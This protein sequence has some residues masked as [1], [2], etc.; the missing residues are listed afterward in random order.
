MSMDQQLTRTLHDQ[1][2]RVEAPLP[3]L[4]A[5]VAGGRRRQRTT[6]VRR[7]GIA[8][9]AAAAV[10]ATGFAI[11]GLGNHKA[12]TPPVTHD[13][14][15]STVHSLVIGDQPHIPFCA[16]QQQILGADA[17][18]TADCAPLVV[19]G[20][21]TVYASGEG[22]QQLVGGRQ[23]LLDSRLPSVW[24]PAVSIDGS[25]AAW[26]TEKPSAPHHAAMVVYDLSDQHQIAE[27]DWPALDGFAAG[28][29][30]RGRVYFLDNRTSHVWVYD[31]S[32]GRT[33]EVTGLPAFNYPGIRFVTADGLGIDAGTFN[34]LGTPTSRSV[35]GTVT[36]NG[37]FVDQHTVPMGWGDFSPDRGH[38][39]Q[40]TADGLWVTPYDGHTVDLDAHVRLQLP[41][42]GN[43]VSR[44]TWESN[45]SILIAF[46][47]DAFAGAVDEDNG[48]P[49]KTT[50][51][52]RCSSVTG[53]CEIAL[54]PGYGDDVIDSM[55]R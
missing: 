13:P 35:I 30:D 50:Y 22:V 32:R 3:D 18:I 7:A 16:G 10:V 6:V 25:Y 29:D 12:A 27:V 40:D 37:D 26:V 2:A 24:V 36:D 42:R 44:A 23:L 52:L 49:V 34:H 5:I 53:Q 46:D 14:T 9:L 4:D 28:I 38:F 21:S 45:S 39:V 1:S 31:I 8:A 47:P 41:Q 43:A 17:P 33:F 51:M 20:G 55:Y 48:I 54:Q 15:P 19:R 11:N